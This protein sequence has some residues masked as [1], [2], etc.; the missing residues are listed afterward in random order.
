MGAWDV[1][2]LWGGGQARA[3]PV[4]ALSATWP[5]ILCDARAFLGGEQSAV[6]CVEAKKARCILQARRKL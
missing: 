4:V 2:G 6:R 3:A 5:P 1:N